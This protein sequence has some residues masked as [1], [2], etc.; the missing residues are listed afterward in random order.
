MI[1]N[2]ENMENTKVID[3][4]TKNSYFHSEMRFHSNC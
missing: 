4:V 1:I 3:F 2:S